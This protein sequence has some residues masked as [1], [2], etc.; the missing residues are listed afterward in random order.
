MNTNGPIIIIEDDQEDQ[1]FMK[2]AIAELS[3]TNE[4]IIFSDAEKALTFLTTTAVEPFIIFSDVNMPKLGGMELRTK[5][6]EHDDL[7]V[8][9]IPFIFLTTSAG[10]QAIVDAY[11]QSIQG[12][13]IKPSTF[14]GLKK[15]LHTIVG[16]WQNCVPPY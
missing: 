4:I 5:L 6:H 15:L 9:A 2:D 11:T 14:S 16:Y 13:F 10:H 7:R 1:E 12:F 3:F 8:K